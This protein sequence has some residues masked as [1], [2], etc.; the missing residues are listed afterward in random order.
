MRPTALALAL[1]AVCPVMAQAPAHENNPFFK[2]WTGP[3]GLP[4][5]AEIKPEHFLPALK[6]GM[7]QQKKRV[8]E[9]VSNPEAPTFKNT[10][11]AVEYSGE[12]LEKVGGVFSNYSGSLATPEIQAIQRQAAPL[13]SAHGDEISLN[14][15]LWGRLKTLW[16][17]RA[18]LKL[19]PEQ[20][21]LLELNVKSFQRAG[22]D[23]SPEAKTRMK[24]IN[25]ELSKLSVAFSEAM[26]K[27]TNGFRIV[28][29]QKADLAGLPEG[30]IAQG[31][32]DAKAAGLAGK[33]VYTLQSPS[34]WPFLTY[35]ENRELRRQ[36]H[37]A[38]LERGNKNDAQDTKKRVSR[39]AAL[40]AEK[41]KLLGFKTWADFMLD[42]RMAKTA[43]NAMGL[44]EQLWTPTMAIAKKDAKELQAMLEKDHKG[45]TLESWDWRFYAERLKKQRYDLDEEA[46]KPYFPID[47]VRDGAF[48]VAKK[49]FGITFTERKDL[50]IYHPEAKVFE[51][52]EGD[53]RHLGVFYVDY[54]PR[55][56][57]RG[58]A[59]CSAFRGAK[60]DAEGKQVTPVVLNTCNFTPPVGSEPALLTVDEVTTLF[61]EFG[62]ALHNLFYAGSYRGTSRTPT[63]F[64]ELPSQIMENWSMEPA[65]LK[66]YARH[67]KTGEPMPDALI[68]KVAKVGKHDQG[69]T[70]GEYLAASILDMKWHMLTE[71]KELDAAVFE[72]ET[73]EKMGALSAI[74]PRYRST[75]FNHIWASGYSAGYYAYIWSAVLDTDAFQ[76]FKEKGDLFHPATAAAFRK[77]VLQRGGTRE[78]ADLYRSFRG[79][80]PKIEA[81]LDKRGLK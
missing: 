35:S 72:K 62:H 73:L 29:D 31:A 51:V 34:I 1:C 46:T 61:H 65:V 49:L 8:A 21:R 66:T 5:F 44:L 26:L 25:A 76:A 80:D 38:Y 58:G 18:S 70:T 43:K 69:L 37:T 55:A 54:H 15:A 48:D 20:A 79:R 74:P 24:A 22:A 10:V 67:H 23:L 7:A 42:D 17:Q 71:P 41:A 60:K 13:M 75:Y 52:K 56:I 3:F 14:D 12:F 57:K 68:E 36:L 28:I 16:A 63:D 59:W 2:P 40:R 39:I 6:E 33:W 11:E 77:E 64:V 32:A 47:R 50:P 19:N 27:E 78:A 45:A 53:G 4:P 30:L 81:L 9:I